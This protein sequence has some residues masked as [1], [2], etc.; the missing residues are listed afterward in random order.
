MPTPHA[1]TI[2]RYLVSATLEERHV[3]AVGR[4]TQVNSIAIGR[5]LT[6]LVE[7]KLVTV[8]QLK[9]RKVY[10]ITPEGEAIAKRQ[11]NPPGRARVLTVFNYAGGAGKTS[12]TRD[13]GYELSCLGYRVLLIDCDPQASLTRWLGINPFELEDEQTLLHTIS[14]EEAGLP[15]PIECFGMHLI[16]AS[17]GLARA[18]KILAEEHFALDRLR[19]ARMAAPYDLILMDAQPSASKLTLSTTYASDQLIVPIPVVRKGLDTLVGTSQLVRSIAS[20][21]AGFEVLLYLPTLYNAGL[22]DAQERLEEIRAQLPHLAPVISSR[23]G[24]YNGAQNAGV[25]I[26]VFR[27]HDEARHEVQ[28]VVQYLLGRLNLGKANLA[29]SK[30]DELKLS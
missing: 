21:I 17:P 6:E 13:L 14:N 29:Y 26:G 2:L 18:E 23:P 16:P 19:R 9:N 28:A 3:N 11:F 20:R 12:T 30:D 22:R 4:G 5:A 15:E 7:L 10:A 25:P 1:D 8:D 24:V 27:P